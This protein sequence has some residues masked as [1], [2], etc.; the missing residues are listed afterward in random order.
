MKLQIA[1]SQ[2][3]AG[4]PTVTEYQNQI[5]AIVTTRNGVGFFRFQTTQ[6]YDI[7][8][9]F[10]PGSSEGSNGFGVIPIAD[11]SA[12]VQAYATIVPVNILGNL[13][14]DWYTLTPAG[15]SIELSDV[16]GNTLMYLP[17]IT[18]LP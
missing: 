17:D 5:G 14:I 15:G 4:V 16:V 12:I 9:V 3:A 7:S 8:K 13:A 10:I 18:I 11:S 6:P 1:I 2:V